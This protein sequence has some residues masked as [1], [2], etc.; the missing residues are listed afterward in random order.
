MRGRVIG[1]CCMHACEV[2]LFSSPLCLVV[3]RNAMGSVAEQHPVFA[4][5]VQGGLAAMAGAILG[6]VVPRSVR[7]T[8]RGGLQW[9]LCAILMEFVDAS[10]E[11]VRVHFDRSGPPGGRF[12]VV[13]DDVVHLDLDEDADLIKAF[14]EELRKWLVLECQRWRRAGS[15]ES[16]W[17]RERWTGFV[18]RFVVKV[19]SLSGRLVQRFDMMFQV[20]VKSLLQLVQ[21]DCCHD[22]GVL[23]CVVLPSFKKRGPEL[24][25]RFPQH[26]ASLTHS[27][28]A[29]LVTTIGELGVSDHDGFDQVV[30]VVMVLTR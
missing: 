7:L 18:P 8:V 22:G 2:L 1:S 20:S 13:V 24:E 9:D 19:H 27:S 16:M 28:D 12:R 29:A 10:V 23:D 11:E 14:D 21:Q 5:Y 17:S 26:R 4:S 25:D 15:R 3:G 30:T 6:E